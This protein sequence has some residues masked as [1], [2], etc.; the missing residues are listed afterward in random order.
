MPFPRN[1]PIRP[2]QSEASKQAQPAVEVS[3]PRAR[4]SNLTWSGKCTTLG[5]LSVAA[6]EG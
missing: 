3:G 4:P 2:R 5:N 6:Q 1:L